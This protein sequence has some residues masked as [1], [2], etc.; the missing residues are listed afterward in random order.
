MVPNKAALTNAQVNDTAVRRVARTF[1]QILVALIIG[2]AFDLL[3]QR[4]TDQ[5]P[6][7]LVP[8]VTGL[9]FL[10]VVAAQNW[11]ENNGVIKPIF[12]TKANVKDDTV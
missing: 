1:L 4:L 12:G 2:G 10:G 5:T 7:E 8:V 11:A 3:V 9:W 6:R